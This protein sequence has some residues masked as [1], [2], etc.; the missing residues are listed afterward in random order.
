MSGFLV[1]RRS[2]PLGLPTSYLERSPFD[3]SIEYLAARITDATVFEE[4]L[5]KRLA[6]MYQGV[7]MVD[8]LNR[9]PEA[10]RDGR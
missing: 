4:A 10:Y 9:E 1:T 6:T 8:P 2:Q 5:A 7:V 3:G